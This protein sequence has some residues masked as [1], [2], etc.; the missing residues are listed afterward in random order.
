MSGA[1]LVLIAAAIVLNQ[2]VKNGPKKENDYRDEVFCTSNTLERVS[3]F[4]TS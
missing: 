4:M 3:G 2:N 1:W